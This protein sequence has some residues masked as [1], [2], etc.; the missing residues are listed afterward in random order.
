V[1]TLKTGWLAKFGLLP[2]SAGS[3]S[4]SS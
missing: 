2:T 4:V 1:N 3:P